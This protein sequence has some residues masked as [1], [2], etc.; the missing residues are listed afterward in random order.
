MFEKVDGGDGITL[1]DGVLVAAGLDAH[2][3]HGGK[4]GQD[5]PRGTLSSFLKQAGLKGGDR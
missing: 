5:V 1:G 4:E 3:D 2:P